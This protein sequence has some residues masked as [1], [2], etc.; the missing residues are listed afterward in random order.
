MLYHSISE[1]IGDTP[2]LE[3]HK[4]RIPNNNRI[5][6]KCEFCNPAGSIKDRIGF[7]ILSSMKER[8]QIDSASIIVE[9][10]AG[11]TGLGI[12]LGAIEVGCKA[13][14][15][16]PEYFSKEKQ[17]LIKALGAEICLTPKDEGMQGAIKKAQEILASMPNAISFS[18]FENPD[19]PRAHYES[20]AKEIYN[21]MASN[22]LNIDY[23]VCGAGSGGSFSG[24]ARYL[25]ERSFN[26]KAVLCDPLSSI[27]GG[28]ENPNTQKSHQKSHIEGIGNDFI[29]KTMDMS[30]IDEVYK[31]SDEEA[32][33]GMR[34]LAKSEGVLAGISAGA[35][36]F[37]CMKL[38]QKVQNANI[39]TILPDGLDR[40]ISRDIV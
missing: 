16:I 10:T 2:L 4:I 38:A 8:G 26:T 17:A 21:D 7:Y 14:L 30:L 3:L 35:S 15:V 34:M 36:F 27:I 18:Q 31:I 37:A 24:V 12:A 33:E 13:L 23:F 20:T 29:P 6:V 11:N 28:C 9:A 39:L 1:L 25:K 22:G 19:N 5:F 32:Y 40:Y